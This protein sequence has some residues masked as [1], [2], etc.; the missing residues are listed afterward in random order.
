[1]ND[2][3]RGEEVLLDKNDFWVWSCKREK[4]VK[5]KLNI[6]FL[7]HWR[8]SFELVGEVKL[9]DLFCIMRNMS[10]DLRLAI[11]LVTGTGRS[12]SNN[13]EEWQTTKNPDLSEMKDVSAIVL[14][15][16]IEINNYGKIKK[17]SVSVSLGC[18]GENPNSKIPWGLEFT[19][20]SEL[21]QLPIRIVDHVELEETKW[22]K[23]K[24]V[25]YER[26]INREI[27]KVK[28]R[29]LYDSFSLSD[30]FCCLFDDLCFCD[31]SKVKFARNSSDVAEARKK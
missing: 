10:P 14:S 29:K 23:C 28:I 11:S 30:F 21:A 25:F 3:E 22:K 12:F 19:R 20:W 26:T 1:M 6:T 27:D 17:P 31:H 2:R 7:R 16:L 8:S 13:L 15:K 24:K 9:E 5:M 18:N 4:Y